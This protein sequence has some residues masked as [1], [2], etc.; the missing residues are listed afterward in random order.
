MHVAVRV[1]VFYFLYRFMYIY[2]EN[3]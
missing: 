2:A 3:V 1:C